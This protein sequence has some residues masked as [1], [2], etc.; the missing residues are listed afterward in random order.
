MATSAVSSTTTANTAAMSTTTSTSAT[1]AQAASK[2]AAQK[3]V[4]SLGSGSGVDVN[5]LAQNLVDAERIPRQ[6][7]IQNKID[8]NNARVSGLSAMMYMLSDLKTKLAALK[9]KSGLS[10]MTTSSSSSALS[11]TAVAGA[12]VGS[13]EIQINKL[14]TAQRVISAA[15][16]ASDATAINNG[17]PFQLSF[18]KPGVATGAAGVSSAVSGQQSVLS[19]I[20]LNGASD[21]TSFSVQL[22]GQAVSVSPTLGLSSM[23]DLATDL[24]SKLRSRMSALGMTDAASSLTVSVDP[25]QPTGLRLNAGSGHTVAAPTF[26][27]SDHAVHLDGASFSASN[28]GGDF[29]DFSLNVAGVRQSLSLNHLSTTPQ[30][31][32]TDITAQL[33]IAGLPDITAEAV[34]TA[35]NF[36]LYFKDA[37][38]RSLTQPTLTASASAVADGAVVGEASSASSGIGA[39]RVAMIGGIN[40]GGG[41]DFG[42]LS[43]KIDGVTVTATPQRGLTALADM[44]AD[45]QAQLRTASGIADLTVSV[46]PTVSGQIN[47]SSASQHTY[48]NAQLAASTSAVHLDG[49]QFGTTP[50]TD[51]FKSFS[52]V[53]G[54]VTRTITPGP[55]TATPAALAADLQS[56]LQSLEGSADV[57]VTA[58]STASGFSLYLSSASNRSINSPKLQTQVVDMTPPVGLSTG[59]GSNPAT[60]VKT[61]T[62]SGA[63]IAGIAL[64]SPSSTGNLTAFSVTIDGVVRSVTPSA[65]G[66]SVTDLASDLQTQLRSQM[67]SNDLV[68]SASGDTLTFSSSSG[69]TI[70]SP[71]LSATSLSGVSFATNNPTTKDFRGFGLTVDGNNFTIVPS[72]AA[73]TLEA[74]AADLQSQLRTQDGKNDL[75]V[76]VVNGRLQ[77]A[78]ASGRAITNPMLLPNTY[79]LTPAGV[80]RAINDKKLGVTAQVVN[81]GSSS[82]P[83]KLVIS[84]AT[85]A[86]QAFDISSNTSLGNLLSFNTLSTAGN[87]EIVVDGVTMS[88]STNTVTDAITGV[89]LNLKNTTPGGVSPSPASLDIGMDSASFKTKMTDMV[90][91]FNDTWDLLNQVSDPKSTLATYGATLV[92]DSTVRTVKQQIRAMFQGNSTTPGTTVSAFWQIG[93][94]IDEKGVMAFDSAT[95]DTSMQTHYTDVVKSLTGNYDNLSAYSSAPAGFAGDAVRKLT[96]LLDTSQNGGPILSASENANTQN[97][98]YQED[99]TKLQTRMDALLARY[100]KQLASM[101]SL[102]G[103]TNTKKTSLKSTFDGMMSVYTKN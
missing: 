85:G 28:S 96:K 4:T 18:S 63:T 43:L 48:S 89:T 55:A 79:E 65:G 3:L 9:D 75:S 95:F 14:A 91:S 87:A 26:A 32:A 97:T 70:A 49:I 57:T 41:S 101:D 58:Q 61:G 77:F 31:L 1:A 13:H 44:A 68:V 16:F 81:T 29:T 46:D 84:S 38:G 93:I 23:A 47:I 10:T 102:V 25:A 37:Q 17:Q 76:L 98:K 27:T 99:L 36:R 59:T 73:A 21:F 40:L 64:G 54:G 22:D 80:A 39:E 15:G 8:K 53:I 69:K 66:S 56:Q 62:S 72:P 35:G 30:D 19:G 42:A 71:I 92:G 7:A 2:A 78:S 90:S 50:A 83:Y 11:A 103:N 60:G 12:A 45:L 20:D 51:D 82:N 6:T 34:G 88:R 100:Q 74:L 24:Q 67:G 86:N 94:K 52:V 5:S 33:N